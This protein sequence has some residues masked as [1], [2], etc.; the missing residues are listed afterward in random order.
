MRIKEAIAESAALTGSA[1]EQGTLCRW[2]SEMD[3]RLVMEFFRGESWKPY[4]PE[5]DTEQVLLVPAPWD[6]LYVHYL[7]AMTY[8]STGEYSRY[9]NALTMAEKVL[10]DFKAWFVRTK[11]AFSPVYPYWSAQG[12]PEIPAEDDA[13]ADAAQ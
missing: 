7:E 13:Q 11:P 8:Y 5:Q 4:D 3:G 2:L 10:A 12:Q 1:L 9:Q 6:G